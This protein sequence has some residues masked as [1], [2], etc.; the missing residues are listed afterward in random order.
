MRIFITGGTGF[1]G[2]YTVAELI[3]KNHRILV[4]SPDTVRGGG[5]D[6]LR[7]NLSDVGRWKAR[8]KTFKPEAAVHLA[9]EGIPDFSYEQSVKNLKYGLALFAALAEAGSKRI[10]VAGTGF[11]CGS[12]VG[13]I[14]D[15]IAILP[16]TPFTAAKHSLHLMG[17][18]LAKEKGMDFIWL[19]PY[20]PYGDGQRAGSLIPYIVR[21]V[22]Q[23]TVLT[24][25]QPLAQGDFVYVTDVARA[26]A[27]AAIHGK[28]RAT[29]N[30]GSG[31]LT[32]VRDIARL[33]GE[34]M[35]VGKA[36][37]E[38]FSHTARG[39]LMNAAYAGLKNI[40]R[41]IGW[42]PLVGIKKGIQKTIQD[43]ENNRHRV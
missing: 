30:V 21:S 8:L 5:A 22:A 29:Y 25:R 10:V 39:K 11:E 26:F 7:G 38:A 24:L 36:Y 37:Y 4:L 40:R 27:A 34:E 1:I 9:W 19:R 17:E 12:R 20:N 42:R 6:V 13:E 28:G 35:G 43:Y 3:K 14:D 23:K 15:N 18:E 31:Y 2:R 32:P 33:I 41:D 16:A